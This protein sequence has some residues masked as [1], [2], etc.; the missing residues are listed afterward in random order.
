VKTCHKAKEEI[1]GCNALK[2]KKAI[3]K[4]NLITIFHQAH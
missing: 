3:Q 2:E 4:Q 1:D